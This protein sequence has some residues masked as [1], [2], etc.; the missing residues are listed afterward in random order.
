VVF[1]KNGE[2]QAQKTAVWTNIGPQLNTTITG[3]NAVLIDVTPSGLLSI[4]LVTSKTQESGTKLQ[5]GM[6]Q[7]TAPEQDPA[8]IKTLLHSWYLKRAEVVFSQRLTIIYPELSWVK[9]KPPWQLRPMKKQWGSCP[10]KGKLP[11]NPHLVKAPRVCI[12]YVITHELCHLKHHNHSEEFYKFL[13]R[14]LPNWEVVEERL[15]N[16]AEQIL[17]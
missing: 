1:G 10:P 12:D 13:K 5:R 2:Y 15:D 14:Q 3:V 8:Y 17:I 11:L 9:Q 16:L 7:V 4:A 6:L